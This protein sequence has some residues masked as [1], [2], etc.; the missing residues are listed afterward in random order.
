MVRTDTALSCKRA[1]KL[2]VQ[3]VSGRG[4]STKHMPAFVCGLAPLQLTWKVTDL[5]HGMSSNTIVGTC[6]R[7][8]FVWSSVAPNTTSPP[9]LDKCGSMCCA[10]KV[11]LNFH[12]SSLVP[13]AISSLTL[14]LVK[15]LT[16]RML[17][18]SKQAWNDP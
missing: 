11:L 9:Q 16:A 7:T 15:E 5:E 6:M 12:S 17:I 14:S 8:C 10:A 2:L 3:S 18:C 13:D 1:T 4:C